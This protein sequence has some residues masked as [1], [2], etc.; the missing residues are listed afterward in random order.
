M[1]VVVSPF[2]TFNVKLTYLTTL[3]HT[4]KGT[5]NHDVYDHVVYDFEVTF[6]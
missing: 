1:Y 3:I 6:I 2:V 4:D 5:L